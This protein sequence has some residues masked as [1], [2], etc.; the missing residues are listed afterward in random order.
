MAKKSELKKPAERR[1][2]MTPKCKFDIELP[3]AIVD[4]YA[5]HLVS[6]IRSY[7]VKENQQESDKRLEKGEKID[8]SIYQ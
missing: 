2:W 8:D 5:R 6:E 7:Y 3:Q 1:H 4:S